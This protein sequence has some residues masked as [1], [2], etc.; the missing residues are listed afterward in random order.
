MTQAQDCAINIEN[1]LK[2]YI[3]KNGKENLALNNINLKVPKGSFFGLLGPNGAG[4]STLINIIAG[5]VNKTSGLVEVC[6]F[7][8][9]KNIN[10]AK[11][12]IGVVP[13]EIV[14][15]PF[16]SVYEALEFQAGYYGVPKSKRRTEEIIRAVGLFDKIKAS[17]R[18][19]SG[20]MKRRLLV[21]K[22]LV[23]S[24][25]ILVLDEPTAGVDVE[26]R[27]QL[28]DYV[29]ELNNNG[30]TILLTT[31]YLEEA[32]QLCDR[33]AVINKGNI[34]ANDSKENLMKI[35]DRK[36]IEV[37]LRDS[38][39]QIPQNLQKFKSSLPKDNLLSIVYSPQE[40]EFAEILSALNHSGLEISDMTTKEANLHDVFLHLI[41]V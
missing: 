35:I 15:D 20:G 6:G 27:Q 1:L 9:D 4:K 23:H 16:F 39:T 28:W 29:K 26:L 30:I 34:V 12:S 40:T 22:A 41:S 25:Q 18:S 17:P 21:A 33:I 36:I 2:I 10:Q 24:P 31:H 13:Q 8:I 37:K 5:L 14:F 7:D 38:V 32:Q 3:S 19:L 11:K